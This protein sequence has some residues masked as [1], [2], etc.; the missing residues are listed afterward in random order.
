[1]Y[2]WPSNILTESTISL[3]RHAPL[4]E[5]PISIAIIHISLG[6]VSCPL[7]EREKGG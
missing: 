3:T 2:M 7:G 6:R 5:R 1:M 4:V